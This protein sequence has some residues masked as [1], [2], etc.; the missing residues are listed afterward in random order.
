SET[1]GAD[2]SWEF[3]EGNAIK[4]TIKLEGKTLTLVTGQAL[5]S[6]LGTPVINAAS[7]RTMI[8]ARWILVNLGANVVWDAQTTTVHVYK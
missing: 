6:G 3:V 4:V 7:G 1:L 5:P 8:P 2:V